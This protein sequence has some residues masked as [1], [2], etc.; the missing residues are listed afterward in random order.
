MEYKSHNKH[1]LLVIQLLPLVLNLKLY[2]ILINFKKLIILL[3]NLCHLGE[4]L[5]ENNHNKLK[6]YK[7]DKVIIKK[8]NLLYYKKNKNKPMQQ[9]VLSLKSYHL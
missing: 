2:K 6:D 7:K 9:K 4:K 8:Y 5:L 3:N 1:Q